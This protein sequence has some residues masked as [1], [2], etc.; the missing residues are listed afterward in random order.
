MVN[1]YIM[2][3]LF[4]YLTY[5]QN[6]KLEHSHRQR[7]EYLATSLFYL[8]QIDNFKLSITVVSNLPM[9]D[10][11]A[12]TM[13]IVSRNDNSKIEL[14]VA[15]EEEYSFSGRRFDWLLTWVHKKLMQYDFENTNS[16]SGDLFL[17]LEDDALFTSANLHYFLK[18]REPLKQVGL[19]PSF[20]RSE[21]SKYDNCWTHEDPCG[22]LID[23]RTIFEYPGDSKLSLMQL[24]NPFSASICLDYEL[25]KEYFSS[26]S[27]VQQKACFKHPIIYDIGST[28][29]LGLI[30]ENVPWGYLNRVAV[31]CSNSDNYPIPGSIFRHLGDRYAHDKWHRNIRMYDKEEFP[32][33]PTHRTGMDYFKR[34][35]LRRDGLIT[36]RGWL[37]KRKQSRLK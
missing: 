5:F 17:V 34:I 19:I 29:T 25:A 31:V 6:G 21:W 28:S 33:L 11:S 35:F 24:R 32:P 23:T 22:R 9:E 8:S 36:L 26:E 1:F 30:M 15:S 13:P 16:R 14:Y 12:L 2:P 4:V 18:H 7:L 27:S 10:F 3:T 20:I 37:R